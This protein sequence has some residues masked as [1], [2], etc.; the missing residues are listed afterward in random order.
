MIWIKKKQEISHNNKNNFSKLLIPPIDTAFL[1]FKKQ[2][3]RI[4]LL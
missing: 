2:T 3:S 1:A 4:S